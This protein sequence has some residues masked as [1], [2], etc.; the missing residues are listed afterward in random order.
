MYWDC[1]AIIV[2]TL[3][4]ERGTTIYQY[5]Y[6]CLW[7]MYFITIVFCYTEVH[8]L[9]VDGLADH[10]IIYMT[11]AYVFTYINHL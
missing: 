4:R 10:I 5:M 3:P 6:N 8:N 7:I 2:K 9:R 11:Q 1:G